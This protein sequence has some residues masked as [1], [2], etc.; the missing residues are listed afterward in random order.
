MRYDGPLHDN[1]KLPEMPNA[2]RVILS[3]RYVHLEDGTGLVHTA[4]GHGKEDF[5]AGT[6]AGLPAICPVGIDG[7]LTKEAGKYSGKKARVVDQEIIKDLEEQGMLVYKHPH[8]HDYPVCWRCETPL[9][10]VGVP[11]WFFKV[12]AIRE[13]LLSENKKVNWVPK[14]AG[15]RFNDW[16]QNL[17]D[18]PIS[19][20]RYWGI[21]LPIWECKKCGTIEVIGSFEELKKRSIKKLESGGKEIDFHRP[22]IDDVKLKCSKCCQEISRV[23]D[24]LDVWFDSGVCTWASLGYPRNR[25]LFDRMWPSVFQT[26]GPDQFRGWWNSQ[27]IT[28]VLT[29][30]KAPFRNILQ[31]GL[32]MDVKGIKLSKSKGNFIDPQ[33][34][35]DKYGRD[36]LRFYLLSKPVWNDFYFNWEEIKE[37]GSMFNVFWNSYEFVKTYAPKK[38]AKIPGLLIE[39]RWIISRINSLLEKGKDVEKFE[40]HKL[41]QTL[42]DFILNDFSRW[43]IKVIRDRVSPWYSGSDKD[44]AVYALNYVLENVVKILAPVTPFISEHIYLDLYTGECMQVG[45]ST[46]SGLKP[47]AVKG[48]DS[49][50][51]C[52]LPKPDKKLIDKCMEAGMEAVKN[53]IETM[54]SARQDMDVKLRWPIKEVLISPAK[55]SETKISKICR[56]FGGVIKN[57]G[58]VKEINVVKKLPK[59]KDF[60]MGK[61]CLGDVM[62][63]EAL[64][65][66]LIR[67]VQ[68]SRKEKGLMVRDNISIKFDSDGKTM[69][70]LKKHEHELL[71]GVGAAKAT[72]CRID[73]DGGGSLDFEGIKV[74][75]EFEKV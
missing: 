27:I 61:I 25:E 66:E 69:E 43:Y 49:V 51:L 13:K 10:Q 16:L 56:D 54:N 52:P 18:W 12:T 46:P 35:I 21:P 45:N 62:I 29:F 47:G 50:H 67:R 23:P 3:D 57:M 37:V 60:Q 28:S 34:V 72:F 17:G 36:V 4:P 20:Q 22:E 40:I 68:V 11:Q 7:L 19:R 9:L 6:K 70:K 24:V 65:R 33:E 42:W 71:S 53:M 55:G 26:E 39:D 15:D 73:G 2:Y 48:K 5:D 30:K 14:F 38:P 59:G 64:L 32:V 63:D 31:H 8:T 75:F 74:K 1:L 44:G 58:N 41:V